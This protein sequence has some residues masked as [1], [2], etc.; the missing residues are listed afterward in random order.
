MC[1]LAELS[2]C[3]KNSANQLYSEDRKLIDGKA[4]EQAITAQ[5]ARHLDRELSGEDVNVDC[6]YNRDDRDRDDIKRD[7]N[8]APMRPDIIVH[9]RR[10]REN[11]LAVEVKPF[12]SAADRADDFARL[13][14]L[15]SDAYGYLLGVHLELGLTAPSVTWFARG[16]QVGDPSE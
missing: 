6:E 5:L 11:L 1:R 2:R 8:G 10:T 13:E 3:F 16:S 15:T 9:R 7:Q 14:Y 4:H 12:W